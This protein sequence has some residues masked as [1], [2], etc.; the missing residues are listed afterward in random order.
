MIKTFTNVSYVGI[1]SL[2]KPQ[3][4]PSF[5][6]LSYVVDSDLKNIQKVLRDETID[7]H[8]I[9]A[10]GDIKQI[11]SNKVFKPI[12][13]VRK[14]GEQK[15]AAGYGQQQQKDIFYQGH[16]QDGAK[17]DPEQPYNQ[18]SVRDYG[19]NKRDPKYRGIDN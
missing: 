12:K 3:G 18:A 11:Y 7:P 6:L 13:I 8:N 10:C 2:F 15:S 19:D 14:G 17:E 9:F 1:E 5:D 16:F 4:Y